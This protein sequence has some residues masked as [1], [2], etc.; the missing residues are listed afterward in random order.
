MP[1]ISWRGPEFIAHLRQEVAKGVEK[2]AHKVRNEIV[3][4]LSRKASGR[5]ATPSAPGEPPA[6]DTGE[7]GRSFYVDAK[8]V[9]NANPSARVATGNKYARIHEFGG[10]I[11]PVKV[12][13]LPVPLNAAA[14]K[15]LRTVGSGGLKTV[16]GLFV[17]KRGGRLFLVRAGKRS[18]R[19]RKG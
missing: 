17:V 3:R 13:M 8:G 14:R 19:N 2:A 1:T 18:K 4:T 6:K 10:T 9:T 5:G 16:P 7:L 11:R 15:I 12:K